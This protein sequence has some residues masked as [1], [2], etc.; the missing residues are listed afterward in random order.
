[1]EEGRL[2]RTLKRKNEKMKRRKEQH[3]NIGI[4]ARRHIDPL[5][6]V[7]TGFFFGGGGYSHFQVGVLCAA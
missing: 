6:R 5:S 2:T 3:L 7:S 1:M 4:Q